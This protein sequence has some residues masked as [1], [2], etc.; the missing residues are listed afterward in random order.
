MT[1]AVQTEKIC[2]VGS[3]FGAKSSVLVR[4][5]VQRELAAA[6]FGKGL[7]AE[8]H[9]KPN[10]LAMQLPLLSLVP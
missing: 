5:L 7:L 3:C 4:V 10:G 8:G 1:L 9:A 2:P 6:G